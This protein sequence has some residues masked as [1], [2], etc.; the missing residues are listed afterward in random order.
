MI[1]GLCEVMGILNVTPDSFSDGGNF[2]SVDRATAHA[3]RLILEGADIIDV[4][5]ESTRPGAHDV[6]AQTEEDRVVPVITKILELHPQ[7]RLS[8]DTTK[9]KVADAAVSAGARLINDVSAGMLDPDILGVAADHQVDLCLMHMKGTPRTMQTSP[10]YRDVVSEVRE[11]LDQR[12]EAAIGAGVTMS[13]IIIDPGIGFGKTPEHNLELLRH[14]HV[15]RQAGV[16]VLLGASRKSVLGAVT[17][18]TVENRLAASLA[19][20]AWAAAQQIDMVRV[21]DVA[22]TVDVLKVWKAIQG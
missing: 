19:V 2:D 20:V 7:A 6:D 17:G 18:R 22:E 12:I 3:T 16:R 4:G 8:I 1:S 14:L 13:K 9:A 11:Y 21:H 5:G 15:F 10:H